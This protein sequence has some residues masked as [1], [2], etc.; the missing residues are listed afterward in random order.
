MKKSFSSLIKKAKK[1]ESSSRRSHHTDEGTHGRR[2]EEEE[3][4]HQMLPYA[5]PLRA[6]EPESG[7]LL[8]Q[9]QL[10]K[11]IAIRERGFAH[12]SIIDPVLLDN[13]GMNVEFNTVFYTIGWGGFWQIPE[14]GIKL[15]TQ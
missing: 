10:Q 9:G 2:E 5:P 12:M 13:A 3:S 7:L 4:Y 1:G 15:L 6:R 14:L 8:N 11:Y